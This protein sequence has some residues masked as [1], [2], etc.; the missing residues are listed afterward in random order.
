MVLVD[1]NGNLLAAGNRGGRGPGVT[2]Q[3]DERLTA[4]S[5]YAAEVEA[6]VR[7]L[8]D[9]VLGPNRSVVKASVAM[10][11][12][13]REQTTQS[14]DPDQTVVRSSQVVTERYG[15]S[16]A[17]AGGVPG[18]E[19]NLPTEDGATELAS[20]QSSGYERTE[21]VTN[22]EITQTEAHET[23]PAGQIERVSL[24]VLV[25]GVEQA[26]QLQTLKSAIVAAAGID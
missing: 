21:E 22:F 13:E 16:D 19:T 24:S 4:E 5:A 11:W 8:L 10:D 17:A 6:N 9:T 23:I 26:A 18:A 20:E 25:D 7:N 12:T 2:G 15:A 1:V 3:T 14:F